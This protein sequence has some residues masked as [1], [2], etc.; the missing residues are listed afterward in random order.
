MVKERLGTPALSFASPLR[1][2]RLT[3]LVTSK[4][5]HFVLCNDVSMKVKSERTETGIKI[6]GVK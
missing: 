2:T 4:S 5:D 3:Q 1:R 6:F